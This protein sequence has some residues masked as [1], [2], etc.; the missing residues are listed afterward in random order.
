MGQCVKAIAVC[1]LTNDSRSTTMS[2]FSTIFEKLKSFA[3]HANAADSAPAP[4]TDAG[5]IGSTAP[6]A[7]ST[8]QVDVAAVLDNLSTQKT[9]IVDLLK[10]LDIDSSLE[11]RKELAKELGVAEPG[12][13]EANL[14]L[15]K[16]VL[17]KLSDNGGKVPADLLD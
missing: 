10:L 8:P 7:P 2:I 15:H 13:A 9:S 4:T 3:T 16:A 14:A 6:A 17:K 1:L 12:S 11:H 5:P